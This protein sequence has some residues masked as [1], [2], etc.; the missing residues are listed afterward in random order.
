[1]INDQF[2]LKQRAEKLASE[3]FHWRL[4]IARGWLPWSNGEEILW[5]EPSRS[6]PIDHDAQA[7]MDGG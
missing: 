1:M 4:M 2:F 5:C 6:R 7:A 3:A